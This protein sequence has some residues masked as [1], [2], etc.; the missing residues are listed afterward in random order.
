MSRM[1]N[2]LAVHQ[3]SRVPIPDELERA[4]S[5]MEARGLG[6]DAPAGYALTA[7]E[8]DRVRGPVFAAELTLDGWFDA[9]HP[10]AGRLLPIAEAAGDGSIVALWADP[11]DRTRVVVLGS[12]GDGYVIAES[13][14]DLLALLAVGYEEFLDFV[15]AGP[16]DDE[17]CIDAVAE[18]RAWVEE[19]LEMPVPE[20]WPS[21][22]DDDF[23]V[24]LDEQLGRELPVAAAAPA[25]TPNVAVSGDV[26]RLIAMLGEPD[27]AAA[28]ATM[29]GILGVELGGTLRNSPKALRSAGLEAESDRN[30][31]R[32][33]WIR[34]ADYPRPDDLISGLTPDSSPH[35]ALALLGEPERQG[36]SWVRYVRDGRYVRLGFSDAGWERMTLM[37]EAP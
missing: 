8:G 10:A 2:E 34:P 22:G 36:S 30:G 11:D 15:L 13:A 5:W 17:A 9:V 28:A 21:V 27:D 33:V 35:D 25:D 7:Y 18:F 14:R 19:T 31:I 16:P 29:A 6:R 3:S 24:W 12:D 23:S 37:K 4:W 26:L 20:E 1:S 32:T